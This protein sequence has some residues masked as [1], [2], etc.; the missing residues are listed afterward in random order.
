LDSRSWIARCS[1]RGRSVPCRSSSNSLT[2]RKSAASC[3]DVTASRMYF[4]E[5]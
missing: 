4:L 3:P 2:G 1:A 5:I